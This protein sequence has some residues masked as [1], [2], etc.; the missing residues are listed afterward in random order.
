MIRPT[1]FFDSVN[2]HVKKTKASMFIIVFSSYVWQNCLKLNSS[3]FVSILLYSES[4]AIRN[5]VVS[6]ECLLCRLI[7]NKW[8]CQYIF[9]WIF[10]FHFWIPISPMVRHWDVLIIHTHTHIHTR[11]KWSAFLDKIAQHERFKQVPKDG[12]EW[13]DLALKARHKFDQNIN[14]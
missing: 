9:V 11:E 14:S 3:T 4:N 2:N 7:W 10:V 6:H 13:F 12:Q 5:S 1:V 8:F